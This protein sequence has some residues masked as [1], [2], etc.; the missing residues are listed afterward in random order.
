MKAHPILLLVASLFLSGRILAADP[1]SGT[2][3]QETVTPPA[4][5][6][7]QTEAADTNST[8][9]ATTGDNGAGGLRLNFRGA[10]LNLV[11]DYLSDAAG[12]I[13]NK[14]ADVRGTVDVWSKDPLSKDEA[15]EVLNA[16]LK[17]NGYAVTRSGR[18][19][20]IVTMDTAKTSDLEIVSGSDFNAVE[21][22]A[23]VVTQ[24]IPVR[25]ANA[26]QLMANLQI[27]LPTSATLSANESANTLI[28]VATKTDIRRMLKVVTALDTSIASVSSIKVIKLDYADAK[29]L[30]TE[31]QQ[32]FAPQSSTQGQ[33]GMNPRAQLFNMFRGG[34]GG[35][36]GGFGGGGAGGAGA[37][38][39]GSAAGSKVVATADEYSN[40]LIVLASSELL[41]TITDMVL[42]S[43][44][45]LC[46]SIPSS[47]SW[48][49]R[50]APRAG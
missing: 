45:K 14:E 37:G 30:A 34:F 18:I 25:Y 7:G 9:A 16:V 49:T 24:I 13:I 2:N 39:G 6:S 8:A 29:Q 50:G 4:A 12:F 1:P 21:K 40:S 15:V 47:R 10:P 5:A 22:S 44:S 36:P 11:L 42:Q 31:V 23:E 43:F 35:G 19:L 28:L 48:R 26:A 27:L 20:T 41:A 17:K 32:L 3:A 38:T 46:S 33:G